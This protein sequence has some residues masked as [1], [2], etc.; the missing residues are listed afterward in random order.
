MLKFQQLLFLHS[1]LPPENNLCWFEWCTVC[2]CMPACTLMPELWNV[3]FSYVF[4]SCARQRTM[5]EGWQHNY[6]VPSRRSTKQGCDLGKNTLSI[7]WLWKTKEG[8]SLLL[9]PLSHVRLSL[10]YIT[11][12]HLTDFYSKHF[13]VHSSITLSVCV[14]PG[15]L[16]HDLGIVSTMLYQ[17][18]YRNTHASL[19]HSPITQSCFS[20]TCCI[21][22]WFLMTY[23]EWFVRPNTCIFSLPLQCQYIAPLVNKFCVR[24]YCAT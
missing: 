4:V 6:P 20:W 3:I 16:I 12:M 22:L 11:F 8:A 14:F 17:P 21:C 9:Q 5:M 10:I 23:L 7:W 2:S 24:F 19:F 15:N 13:A 1:R 18:I